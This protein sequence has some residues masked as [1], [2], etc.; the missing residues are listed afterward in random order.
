MNKTDL[1]IGVPPVLL[2]DLKSITMTC[3]EEGLTLTVEEA[4]N[5]AIHLYVMTI[6]MS[7]ENGKPDE[8]VVEMIEEWYDLYRESYQ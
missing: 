2:N 7:I 1:T 5:T 3:E 4:I 6:T 8:D